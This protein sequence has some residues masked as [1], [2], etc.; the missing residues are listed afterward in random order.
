MA[1]GSLELNM[2]SYKNQMYLARVSKLLFA[3]DV[4]GFLDSLHMLWPGIAKVLSQVLSTPKQ[5]PVGV[6][7]IVSVVRLP[8]VGAT[9]YLL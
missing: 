8:P 2:V 5:H 9:F 6:L 7:I 1:I 3:S 4:E